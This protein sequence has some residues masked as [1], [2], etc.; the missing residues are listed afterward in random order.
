[1]RKFVYAYEYS[2][3]T[4]LTLLVLFYLAWP[5]N[6]LNMQMLLQ[7]KITSFY[8]NFMFYI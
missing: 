4:L 7:I 3:F 6:I 5:K 8:F 2:R 1:M